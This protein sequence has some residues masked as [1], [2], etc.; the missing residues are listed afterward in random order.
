[1]P[2]GCRSCLE[3]TAGWQAFK[4]LR[5]QS[6]PRPLDLILLDLQIPGEDG[7]GVLTRIRGTPALQATPVIAVTA[8]VHYLNSRL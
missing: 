6:P 4:Q 7:Y 8:N 5:T 1:M 3:A 2:P